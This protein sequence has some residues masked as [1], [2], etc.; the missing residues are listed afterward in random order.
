MGNK[1]SKNSI[2][3]KDFEILKKIGEGGFGNVYL[4]RKKD[5]QKVYA[6]KYV[7]IEDMLQRKAMSYVYQELEVLKKVKNKY[8][9]QL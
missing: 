6:L 7:A 9:I 3:E 2:S 1:N 8:V 5:T 4:V